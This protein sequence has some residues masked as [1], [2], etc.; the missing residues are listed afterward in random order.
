[1]FYTG[2]TSITFRKLSIDE[3]IALAASAGLDG[4]EWGSDVHVPQGDT[5]LA[6]SVKAKTEAAGL[7]VC[8]YGSYYRCTDE[9]GEIADFLDSAQALG[10]PVIRVWAGDKG[11]AEVNQ[12]YRDA[13]AER[14]RRMVIAAKELDITIA[15]EYHGNTLTDTQESAHRLLKEVGQPELKLYWQPRTCGTFE[16]DIPELIA[17]LPHMSHVHCF[18]WGPS[19]W[20]DRMALAEG[21]EPWT[22]Y[23]KLIKDADGDRFVIFEFVKGDAPEQL[24][25]DAKVLKQLVAEANA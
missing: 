18:H 5:E 17:A 20:Q 3:I 24:L 21:V 16:G 19:G 15:L 9:S 12:A 6:E 22:E 23:L 14:L 10:A 2:L 25:A 8:S 11:S 1:M 4:I 13:V 7:K